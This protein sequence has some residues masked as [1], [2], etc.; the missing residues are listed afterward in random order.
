MVLNVERALTKHT[1]GEEEDE[2]PDVSIDAFHSVN[3]LGVPGGRRKQSLVKME[4]ICIVL[5]RA[6]QGDS[7]LSHHVRL[8]IMLHIIFTWSKMDYRTCNHMN[9]RK[10]YPPQAQEHSRGKS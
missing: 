2:E 6:K 10:S 3:A 7:S 8:P 5:L 1:T 9:T 4:L